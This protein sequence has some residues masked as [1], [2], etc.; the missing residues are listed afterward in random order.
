MSVGKRVKECLDK[1]KDGDL[2]NA[3]IQLSIA[4][5]AT[6]KK[7]YPND[8]TSKR[9]KKFIKT[10][11]PFVMWSLTNGTPTTCQSLSFQFSSE[12]SPSG[13]TNFE[14]VFY[15]YMRCNLIHE[16]E[17]PSKITFAYNNYNKMEE[18]ELVFPEALISSYLFAVVASP[19]NK[20]QRV[21]D[22]YKFIFG[23]KEFFINDL[24]GDIE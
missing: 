13:F 16:G 2:E 1:I 5:D 6:A 10:N 18:G 20:D 23:K 12:S 17:M 22:D 4:I 11:L 3:F 9:C 8:T 7:E 24:W 15:K 21:P 19:K 14:D